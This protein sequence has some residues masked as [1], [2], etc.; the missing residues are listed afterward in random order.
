M[1]NHWCNST[2][3]IRFVCMV[4]LEKTAA[5]IGKLKTIAWDI[6]GL[7]TILRD[8]SKLKRVERGTDKLSNT[9]SFQ[10]SL[11]TPAEPITFQ[12]LIKIVVLDD[13]IKA[14]K[15]LEGSALGY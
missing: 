3:K 14:N 12:S 7:R 8:N 15:C 1:K 11:R 9:V 13:S 2:E 10:R 5:N 4:S 6:D